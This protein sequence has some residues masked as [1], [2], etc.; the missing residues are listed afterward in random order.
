MGH[1][2]AAGGSPPPSD[3]WSPKC[4]EHVRLQAKDACALVPPPGPHRKQRCSA[5]LAELVRAAGLVL[6]SSPYLPP[7]AQSH[8]F[9]HLT[10]LTPALREKRWQ[11]TFLHRSVASPKFSLSRRPSVTGRRSDPKAELLSLQSGARAGGR[12]T[13]SGR[14]GLA[15]SWSALACPSDGT[16]C[17]CR[18]PQEWGSGKI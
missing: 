8:Q 2:W 11:S 5:T 7:R 14:G 1:P 10:A 6:S 3:M 16:G 12:G 15:P 4:P 9:P 18:G 17:R 13:A